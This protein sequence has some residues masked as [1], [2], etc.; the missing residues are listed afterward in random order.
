KLL[1]D[2]LLIF[3]FCEREGVSRSMTN[4]EKKAHIMYLRVLLIK[5]EVNQVHVKLDNP[6]LSPDDSNN[7][8]DDLRQTY[9]KINEW[10][11]STFGEIQTYF[12]DANLK[13]IEARLNRKKNLLIGIRK[14]AEA[15][16]IYERVKHLL[17]ERLEIIEENSDLSIDDSI[18]RDKELEL[19]NKCTNS[20]NATIRLKEEI[21]VAFD[22]LGEK[23]VQREDLRKISA[24][25][26]E[27]DV[28]LY[29]VIVDTFKQDVQTKNALI[30]TLEK[31]D[32]LFKQYDN[33]KEVEFKVF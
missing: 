9:I 13:I 31:I 15:V 30:N 5:H 18:I 25:T 6:D 26:Q 21:E 28:D 29:D 4:I 10:E 23:G 2:A 7:L 11:K 20:L 17:N 14:I 19:F 22:H 32:D 24:L 33:W 3:E 16:R 12:E 27:F 8:R 1:E